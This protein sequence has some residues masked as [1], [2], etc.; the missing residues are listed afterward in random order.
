MV[1]LFF[2]GPFRQVFISMRA[3]NG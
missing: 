1:A 3:F 2:L